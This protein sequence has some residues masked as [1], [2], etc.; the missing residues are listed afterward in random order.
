MMG[1]ATVDSHPGWGKVAQVARVAG[2]INTLL[3]FTSFFGL[4]GVG[5]VLQAADTLIRLRGDAG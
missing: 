3:I 1:L 2:A 5:L 4:L